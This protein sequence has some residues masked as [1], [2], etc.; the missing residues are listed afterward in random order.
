VATESELPDSTTAGAL[1]ANCVDAN[2]GYDV[3][4]NPMQNDLAPRVLLRRLINPH[5]APSQDNPY[6]T[7]DY[8]RVDS[9]MMKAAWEVDNQGNFPM[10]R[11]RGS[12]ARCSA[13]RSSGASTTRT[14]SG[15]RSGP[16]SSRSRRAR[17]HLTRTSSS[18]TKRPTRPRW[19]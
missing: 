10:P 17:G 1:K 12:R 5:E 18:P 3:P 16:R 11:G 8:F 2:F 19:R 6:I 7:V 15:S 4:F 9:S 14:A 13:R